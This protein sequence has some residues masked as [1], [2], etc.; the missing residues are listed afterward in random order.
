VLHNPKGASPLEQHIGLGPAAGITKIE[1]WWP[2]SNTRQEFKNVAM[3]Q[4]IEIKEFAR[5]YTK[6]NR[7]T[8]RLG[9]IQPLSVSVAGASHVTTAEGGNSE[10]GKPG[11]RK[12]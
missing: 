1:I 7:Q 11:V 4:Y 3:N 8:Y 12:P 9:V 6:L 2:T 5:D 10:V